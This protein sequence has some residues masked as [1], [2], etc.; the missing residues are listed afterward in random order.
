MKLSVGTWPSAVLKN[1]IYIIIDNIDINHF[2]NEIE[3]EK[4]KC[5]L[6][7]FSP[8]AFLAEINTIL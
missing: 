8:K 3:N 6:E 4:D 5:K 1:A 7:F 2:F